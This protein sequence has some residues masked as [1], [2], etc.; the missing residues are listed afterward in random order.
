VRQILKLYDHHP[1]KRTKKNKNK[2][3]THHVL[4]IKKF[5]PQRKKLSQPETSS[6]C[7]GARNQK[8]ERCW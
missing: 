1:Q 7:T 3:E 4:E 6:S 2:S 5:E 8:K